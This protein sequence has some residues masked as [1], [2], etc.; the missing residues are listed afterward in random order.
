MTAIRTRSGSSLCGMYVLFFIAPYFVLMRMTAAHQGP[1]LD[2]AAAEAR[3]AAVATAAN[4]ASITAANVAVQIDLRIVRL[5]SL[6]LLDEEQAEVVV[7]ELAGVGEQEVRG[8]VAAG[9]G[10]TAAATGHLEGGGSVL[11]TGLAAGRDRTACPEGDGVAVP[12]GELTCLEQR[13]VV[14]QLQLAPADG[15]ARADSFELDRV[16]AGGAGGR[17][18]LDPVTP[19]VEFDGLAFETERK[20]ERPHRCRG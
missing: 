15:A 12:E 7:C 14:P 9:T 20:R 4:R 13:A 3:G 10:E 16:P 19:A 6:R 5:L 17:P 11:A 8:D 18:A 2:T 1:G